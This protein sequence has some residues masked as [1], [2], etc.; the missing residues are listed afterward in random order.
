MEGG[1]YGREKEEEWRS[2][3]CNMYGGTL[4]AF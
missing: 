3:G 4:L 1:G 2:L